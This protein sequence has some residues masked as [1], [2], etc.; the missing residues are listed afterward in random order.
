M[1]PKTTGSLSV[2]L[3]GWL[4][5]DFLCDCLAVWLSGWLA[6]WLSDWMTI[7]LAVWLS[8]GPSGTLEWYFQIVDMLQDVMTRPYTYQRIRHGLGRSVRWIQ[9]KDNGPPSVWVAQYPWGQ[10]RVRCQLWRP[11]WSR[12]AYLMSWDART[13]WVEMCLPRE[14]RCACPMIRDIDTFR[15]E[16]WGV[17]QL[18]CI[19]IW[20]ELWSTWED[21]L[22]S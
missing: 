16:L 14:M 9:R 3:S 21:E 6:V 12:R 1:L 10:Q 18:R 8:G 7:C 13:S 4:L 22:T 20:N 5:S 17:C 19:G 11:H 15:M 2:Y